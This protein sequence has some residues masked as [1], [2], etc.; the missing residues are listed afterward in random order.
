MSRNI[1]IINGITVEVDG[2]NVR[3]FE[4]SIYV[5][6]IPIAT[7]MRGE[8]HIIWD[9]D[10]ASI[11]ADGSVTCGN[12]AGNVFAGGS[13]HCMDVEGRINAGGSVYATDV[14]AG[15]DAH[16]RIGHGK[17]NS[18]RVD[19][20]AKVEYGYGHINAGGSVHVRGKTG[21]HTRINAGGSV[22][23]DGG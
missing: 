6:D 12:V 5:D 14:A 9:G 19:S 8:V 15:T 22:H 4:G 13:V 16:V 10:L 18:V 2:S 7:Q 1:I 21:V 17:S 11:K 23:L 20:S 3:V